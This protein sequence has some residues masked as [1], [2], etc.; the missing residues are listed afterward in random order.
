MKNIRLFNLVERLIV[1]TRA[2]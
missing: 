1:G 2:I